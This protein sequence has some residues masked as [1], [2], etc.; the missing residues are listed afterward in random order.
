MKKIRKVLKPG[1]D[2]SFNLSV[3]GGVDSD[4]EVLSISAVNS[5]RALSQPFVLN[6]YKI[7]TNKSNTK[8]KMFFFFSF[9]FFGEK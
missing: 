5:T 7:I 9:L 3:N 2:I 6:G 4:T 1:H 8:C